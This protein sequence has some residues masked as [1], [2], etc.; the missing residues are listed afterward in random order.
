MQLNCL[1]QNTFLL[2][3]SPRG[4]V[5]Y[6]VSIVSHILSLTSC[7]SDSAVPLFSRDVVARVVQTVVDGFLEMDNYPSS[8]VVLDKINIFRP[9]RVF[10]FLMEMHYKIAAAVHHR[11]RH[12][13]GGPV[14]K[15]RN[16]MVG[17]VDSG[18]F[19]AKVYNNKKT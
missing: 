12:R 1:S 8:V 10:M 11:C 2:L 14:T 9:D 19:K 18:S 3:E 5:R 15:T 4:H 13:V 16:K 6:K 17:V 7:S